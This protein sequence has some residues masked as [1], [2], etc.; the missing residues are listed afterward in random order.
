MRFQ[1]KY[2]ITC[3]DKQFLALKYSETDY[4][5]FEVKKSI[6]NIEW[7]QVCCEHKSIRTPDYKKRKTE[8]RELVNI[9]ERIPANK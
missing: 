9:T 4:D 8:Q 7:I 5:Y 6:L 1:S 2:L 3:Y